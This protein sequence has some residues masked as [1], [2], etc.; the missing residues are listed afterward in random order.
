MA[1][2]STTDCDTLGLELTLGPMSDNLSLSIRRSNVRLSESKLDKRVLGISMIN[3]CSLR[4]KDSVSSFDNNWDGIFAN[5]LTLIPFQLH[6]YPKFLISKYDTFSIV[7]NENT[8]MSVLS[9][10]NVC[11]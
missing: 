1:L 11:D 8:R 4:C 6:H 2:S 9:L 5:F 3:D 7:T 10:Q